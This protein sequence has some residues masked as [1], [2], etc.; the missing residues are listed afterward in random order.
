LDAEPPVASFLKSMLIGSGP[1]NAAVRRTRDVSPMGI[2]ISDRYAPWL[3]AVVI[4]LLAWK[5]LANTAQAFSV[6][7]LVVFI[8]S[9]AIGF[10]AGIPFW[11]R[12]RRRGR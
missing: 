4:G 7:G 2:R 9:A 3:I 12:G 10:I 6:P 1:V 11:L 8:G 5:P